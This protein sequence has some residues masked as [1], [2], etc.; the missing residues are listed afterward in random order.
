LAVLA[1]LAVL[2]S[3]R[4]GAQETFSDLGGAWWFELGGD[5]AGALLIG[6]GAPHEGE[7]PV[8]DPAPDQPS[9]GFSRTLGGFFVVAPGQSLELDSKSNVLGAL[10]LSDP[11]SGEAIG[12]LTLERG[13]VDKK[14]Q[15]WNARGSVAG[16]SGAAVPARLKGVRFPATFPVLSGGGP[17]T[18]LSGKG[19]KS[20]GFDLHITSDTV[21][22]VPA[23]GFDGAGPAEID[24][25]EVASTTLTGRFMLTPKFRV[26]GALE[27][28]SD[29]GTGDVDGKLALPGRKLVPQVKLRMLASRK[30]AATSKLTEPIDPVLSVTPS[31][32]FDFGAV[33]LNA[34]AD[35]SFSLLN[36]G[37]GVLSGEAHFLPGS[38]AEF[39]LVSGES[40]DDLQPG[41]PSHAV[42]VRFAPT[43]TGAK[44]AQ[45]LFD[46]GGGRIGAQL[47]TLSGVGGIAQIAVTPASLDFPGIALGDEDSASVTVKN[48]GDGVLVGSAQLGGATDFALSLTD[49]GNLATRIDYS[50]DPGAQRTLFVHFQPTRTGDQ[51]ATLTFSGGGGATVSLTGST[52]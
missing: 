31:G 46:V 41:D 51:S 26:L 2:A 21:L 28:S 43:T 20:Q 10:E 30:L 9:F 3:A 27:A 14:F 33:H 44:S 13:K 5:E 24:G 23:Y 35:T 36:V 4:A 1:L 22:G 34:S 18:K 19:V 6:F 32:S 47:V 45:L 40:Y 16:S 42:V 17:H 39:S 50:L 8:E 25:V 7:V 12:T 48:T 37:A 38:D 29:F 52:P 11:S 15:R 49:P